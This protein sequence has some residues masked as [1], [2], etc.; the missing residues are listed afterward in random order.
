[1]ILNEADVTFVSDTQ[2]R[3][4]RWNYVLDKPGLT[5]HEF[6]DVIRPYLDKNINI[7][8]INRGGTYDLYV[9]AEQSTQGIEH[10][11]ASV[12]QPEEEYEYIYYRGAKTRVKKQAAAA[13]V[14]NQFDDISGDL[15]GMSGDLSGSL[16]AEDEDEYEYRYY[17]GSKTKV[18]K[19]KVP[20]QAS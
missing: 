14:I 10:L 2:L 7:V 1:M 8:A 17:R 5:S 16:I 20:S 6:R 13:A 18:K 4:L 11:M 9:V 12:S 3:Y 15:S 19:R